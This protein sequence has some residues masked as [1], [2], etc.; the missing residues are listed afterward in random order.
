MW[1][2][3]SVQMLI[4]F[5]LIFL[6]SAAY[7]FT[8][9]YYTS[10]D[11]RLRDFMFLYRGAI[12]HHDNIVIVD[13]DEKSLKELGQW[14]WSRNKLARILENI[15]EGDPKVIGLDVMFS[16][17]DGTSPARVLESLDMSGTVQIVDYDAL[18]ADVIERTHAIASY[19]FIFE[20]EEAKMEFPINNVIIHERNRPKEEFMIE[21]N[22]IVINIPQIQNRVESSGY[23][24]TIPD[25]TGLVR[26]IPLVMRY[27][28][29]TFTPLSFEIVRR[30]LGEHEVFVEYGKYGIDHIQV[31]DYRIPT[32]RNG[33]MLI[34]YRGT[35]GTYTYISALDVYHQQHDSNMLKD[36]II[37][38]GSSAIGLRDIRSTPIDGTH[39]GVEIHANIIDNILSGDFISKPSWVETVDLMIILNVVFLVMVAIHY[40]RALTSLLMIAFL[41]AGIIALLYQMFFTYGLA[42]SILFPVLSALLAFISATVINYF[43]E[44]R[45][46]EF[47]KSKFAQK[48]SPQVVEDLISNQENAL[49]R[50]SREVTIFF[51]D[52]RGYATIA[53][54]IGDPEKTIAFLNEYMMPVVDMILA[55]K[56]TVDKFIGDNIMAYWNA[57]LLVKD[58]P[59]V[60][61]DSAMLL[62]D[63]LREFNVLNKKI[64]RPPLNVGVGVNTGTSIVGE[65]GSYGRSDYTVIGDPV[66]IAYRLEDM[67]KVY[68]TNVIVGESTLEKLANPEQYRFRDLDI[69]RLKGKHQPVKIYELMGYANEDEVFLDYERVHNKAME[70]YREGNFKEAR[71]MYKM[72]YTKFEH[73]LYEVYIER[74]DL[75]ERNPNLPFDGTLDL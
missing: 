10:I 8:S 68:G 48:V 5:I 7:L 57:P 31:G 52:I 65:I 23:F 6:L 63:R 28:G 22:S 62:M 25:E 45:Q 13:I 56:G 1:N 43:F 69:V 24:N 49:K 34:N 66:N 47:I 26:S 4:G 42:F 29:I 44:T 16:E 18:L 12:P 50:E 35:A 55:N 2:K 53:E 75:Y 58:H 59:N 60:A 61:C 72:L 21:P 27:Q 41:I 46:K 51:S 9:R 3:L 74:C 73:R 39:P 67:N 15:H 30:Y 64:G 36:K 37:L 32:D 40:M 19:V 71:R 38:L 33:Q 20:P 14:P 17:P 11:N 70:V 54:N